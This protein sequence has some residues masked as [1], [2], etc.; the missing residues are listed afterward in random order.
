MTRWSRVNDLFH[1][2]LARAAAD[3]DLFLAGDCGA[4]AALHN[5]VTSLLADELTQPV[6]ET[7]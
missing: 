7:R 6:P 3:R 1:A 5:D 2:A 4:G